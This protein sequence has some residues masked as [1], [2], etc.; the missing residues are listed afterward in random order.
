[1][2]GVEQEAAVT[3]HIKTNFV[4]VQNRKNAIFNQQRGK[5]VLRLLKIMKFTLNSMVILLEL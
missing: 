1:M 4:C 2:G 5:I 3:S